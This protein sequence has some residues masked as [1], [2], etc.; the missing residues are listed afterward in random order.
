VV[1]EILEALEGLKKS[2]QTRASELQNQHIGVYIRQIGR[3]LDYKHRDDIEI[4]ML[5]RLS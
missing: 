2:Y 4:R 1:E 3:L 5:V